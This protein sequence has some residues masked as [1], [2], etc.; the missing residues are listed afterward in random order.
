M[1][2]H[3]YI[4]GYNL[5]HVL[6][7]HKKTKYN[8]LEQEREKLI[9]LLQEFSA[10]SGSKITV[11]F[12]GASH[13]QQNLTH[14]KNSKTIASVQI[15]FSP[16]GSDADSVIEHYVYRETEKENTFVVSCD[17]TLRETCIGMGVYV[18]RPER[19]LKYFSQIQ[20]SITIQHKYTPPP[21][22]IDTPLREKLLPFLTKIQNKDK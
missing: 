5:L 17:H 19:F 15:L 8:D 18:M 2:Y 9:H 7:Q 11:V 13:E 4:D 1:T 3:Y 21:P 6:H 12:D 22:P 14:S 10:I 16:R 20:H